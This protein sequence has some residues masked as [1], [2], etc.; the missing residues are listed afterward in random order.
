MDGSDKKITLCKIKLNMSA[1]K[2]LLK[3]EIDSLSETA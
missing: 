2:K 3:K 1:Y